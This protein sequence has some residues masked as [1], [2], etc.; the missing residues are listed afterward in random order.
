MAKNENRTTEDV[1]TDNELRMNNRKEMN[2]ELIEIIASLQSINM[3]EDNI[4]LISKKIKREYTAL[5]N[6]DRFNGI[7]HEIRSIISGCGIFSEGKPSGYYKI[8]AKAT[9]NELDGYVTFHRGEGLPDLRKDQKAYWL[10]LSRAAIIEIEKTQEYVYTD[11]IFYDIFTQEEVAE[12]IK[13]AY[14]EVMNISIE[15]VPANSIDD[16]FSMRCGLYDDRP[17]H[18]QQ[19]FMDPSHSDKYTLS[20]RWYDEMVK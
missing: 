8:R 11:S 13:D 17:K 18:T 7:L 9:H 10:V 4:E 3:S 15:P 2:D 16:Y 5:G 20:I 1:M 6:T 12:V 14:P 19:I